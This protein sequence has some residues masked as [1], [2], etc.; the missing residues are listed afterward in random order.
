SLLASLAPPPGLR[1]YSPVPLPLHGGEILF[2]RAPSRPSAVLPR[3]TAA[4]R[5]RNPLRSRPLPAFGR[6]PPFPTPYPRPRA[7]GSDP[8]RFA[9]GDQSLD[10][11]AIPGELSERRDRR[12]DLGGGGF[13]WRV[14]CVWCR[15]E[16]S[17]LHG[18]INPTRSL[19]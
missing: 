18:A 5:G 19:V 11:G 12:G 3:S 6:T 14:G 2:A 1:P 17:N 16:D 4:P 7:G 8:P 15:R 9:P 10:G 13:D